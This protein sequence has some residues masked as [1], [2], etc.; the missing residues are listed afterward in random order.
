MQKYYNET[1]K[2]V[3]EMLGTD[4]DLGLSSEECDNRKKIHGDNRIFLPGSKKSVSNFIKIFLKIYIFITLLV[5]GVCIYKQEYIMAIITGIV[6]IMNISLKLLYLYNNKKEMNY[7]QKLNNSTVTV[8]RDGIKKIIKSEELVIGDIVYFK[9]SN[10]IAA[11]LRII[12]AN[13]IKVDEKNITGENFFKDKF[14]SKIDGYLSNIGEMKN[15]LFK[16]SVIK[17]GDGYGIVV[18]TGASTQLGKLLAMITYANDKHGIVAKLEKK[19]GVLMIMLSIL[20]IVV[21]LIVYFYSKEINNIVVSFVITQTIPVSI[22]VR[23]HTFLLRRD[24]KM[25]GIDLINISTLEN[26]EDLEYIFLDKIGSITKEEAHVKK[27][28]TNDTLYTDKEVNYSKDIN[29]QRILDIVL[30]CNDAVYNVEKDKGTGDLI[31]IGYLRFAGEKRVY[32]SSL[33]SKYKRLFEIPMESDKRVITTVNKYEKGYRANVRGNVDVVLDICKYIMVD[34]IEKE[35]SQEDVEKI[36]AIDFNLSVEGLMA[37]GIAYRSFSYQPSVSENIESN[38]VFVGI[39]ALENPF[40]DGIKEELEDINKKGIIP[41]IFTDDNKIAAF[42]IAEKIGIVNNTG[43]VISGVEMSSLS[44]EEFT[45]V[46]TRVRVF[47]RVT[48]EIKNKIVGMFVREK[49]N[50]AASGDNLGDL[51]ILSISRVGIGK[52]AAP[53]IVKLLSDIFIKENY[54]RGFLKIFDISKSFKI[55]LEKGKSFLITTLLAQILI[56]NLFPFVNSGERI[57]ILS[58]LLINTLIF[59]PLSLII[60]NSSKDVVSSK[61]VFTLSILWVSCYLAGIYNITS[62]FNEILFLIFSCILIGHT[63]IDTKIS[64]RNISRELIILSLTIALMISIFSV[65]IVLNS[66]TFGIYEVIRAAIILLVY[67]IIELLMKKWQ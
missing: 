41:I 1:W 18:E 62:G 65:L 61:K 45:S 8:V 24:L 51:P 66:I 25:E 32:K 57:S 58:I 15:I 34:G 46:L 36:R 21:S 44:E 31:E 19:L 64:F 27:I 6:L 17:E 53:G 39:I 50:V 43:Q 63:V 23:L 59:S 49:Y 55:G 7:L 56:V 67:C 22:I 5:L 14:E 3:A 42:T 26:V 38:L 28:F 20:T 48:P 29:I 13:N 12:E 9:K 40:N 33:S 10:S 52:G 4:I 47:S 16:G 54:L 35:I 11:D 37:Q 30:L 2:K 60:L